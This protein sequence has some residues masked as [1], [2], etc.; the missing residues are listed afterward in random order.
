MGKRSLEEVDVKLEPSYLTINDNI[1]SIPSMSFVEEIRPR[2]TNGLVFKCTDTVLRRPVAIKIWIPRQDDHR[3]RRRQALEEASKIAQLNHKNIVQ[4]FQCLPLPNGWIY[5]VMEYING[6][7]LDAYIKTKHSD[8]SQRFRLWKQIEEAL[9]YSHKLGVF[10][11]DIHPGNI[12]IIDETI[13]VIDF[14]TSIFAYKKIDSEMRE[15]RLL[16]SLNKKMF[17]RYDLSLSDIIDADLRVLNPV[18]TLDILSVWVDIL[19]KWR[20]IFAV[21]RNE[22]WLMTEMHHL[23]FC[24]MQAPLF[25]VPRLVQQLARKKVSIN[26]QNHFNARCLIW[27][28]VFLHEPVIKGPHKFPRWDINVGLNAQVNKALL[29]KIIPSLREAFY[30]KGRFQ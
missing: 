8:F 9:N 21:K 19:F 22:D 26:V 24:V 29:K 15:T 14:G 16:I 7:N 17:P 27:A 20:E 11:G 3:N 23:A 6:V 30:E 10:H 5:S 13:K 28:D 4:I 18:L 1:I 25:S 2:G 12:L